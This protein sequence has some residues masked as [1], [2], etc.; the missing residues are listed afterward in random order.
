MAKIEG[1]P[2][3]LLPPGTALADFGSVKPVAARALPTTSCPMITA[4]CA[5]AGCSPT[6]WRGSIRRQ[7]IRPKRPV[8]ATFSSFGS[9]NKRPTNFSSPLLLLPVIVVAWVA[10][11]DAA[12]A[13][14][15]ILVFRSLFIEL[16]AAA[17]RLWNLAI[18]GAN[19]FWVC[20]AVV[21]L[22]SL[23]RLLL[24]VPRT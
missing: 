8:S 18:E 19:A 9:S 14:E 3:P 22:A 20:L 5:L 15:P 4:R 21:I 11:L 17:V 1:R 2:P 23:N 12:C 16:S 6:G 24:G 13:A 10:G 7:A